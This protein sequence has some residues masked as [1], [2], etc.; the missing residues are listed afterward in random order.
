[1]GSR[2]TKRLNPIFLFNTRSSDNMISFNDIFL[3]LESLFRDLGWKQPEQEDF[4]L[5]SDVIEDLSNVSDGVNRIDQEQQELQEIL[6]EEFLDEK[7][8][9]YDAR[10]RATIDIAVDCFETNG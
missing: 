8:K 1:M 3:I 2:K 6:Y 4:E 9:G 10:G 7:E 5:L